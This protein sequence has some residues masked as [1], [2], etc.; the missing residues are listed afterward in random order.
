MVDQSAPR[1]PRAERFPGSD[2]DPSEIGGDSRP[3]RLPDEDENHNQ[4]L[5]GDEAGDQ[6][7]LKP[8]DGLDGAAAKGGDYITP[9]IPG[10]PGTI[11][12]IARAFYEIVKPYAPPVPETAKRLDVFDGMGLAVDLFRGRN[13]EL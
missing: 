11:F 3:E 8:A 10:S 2:R 12:K 9:P 13:A 1:G 5:D 7:L 4:I 6:N